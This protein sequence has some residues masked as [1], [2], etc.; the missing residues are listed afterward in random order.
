MIVKMKKVSL[1]VLDSEIEES[2]NRLKEVGVLHVE[3]RSVQN[4]QLS[5]LKEIQESFEKALIILPRKENVE[6][7]E[8][9]GGNFEEAYRMVSKALTL[10]DEKR[11]ISEE[12]DRLRREEE[13]LSQW[14]DFDPAE[15]RELAD[16][17][18]RIKLFE[19]TPD[20]FEEVS[21]RPNI[22][23]ISRTKTIVRFAVALLGDEEILKDMKETPIPQRGLSEVRDNIEEKERRLEEID[24]ELL[25][26]SEKQNFISQS[27][28][29]LNE[30]IEFE[31]VKYGMGKEEKLAYL[32]GFAPL[33]KIDILR[34]TASNHGWALLVE[35]PREDDPVPTLIEN[36]KWIRIIQPVFNLMSTV[37]G[38]R[39]Y[40]ISLWFLIFFSLFFAM[41]IGDAGYG[42]LMFGLTLF[43]R[44]KM[45]KAPAEPFLLLFVMCSA[46]IIWGCLSGTWF[47]VAALAEHPAL[48]W[49]IIPGIA[50][51]GS[52][53]AEQIMLLCFTIGSVHIG[54]AHL[55]RFIERLP[56]LASIS[57]LGWISVIAG[58]YFIVKYIALQLPLN[59]VSLWLIGIGLVLVIIFAE[60]SGSFFKGLLRGIGTMPLKFLD[61]ISAFSDIVS[62]VRLFAVGLATVEVAKS[63]NAMAETIGFSIPL[64][65][66]SA[67]ILFFGH[68]LNIVMGVMAVVVHGIRLNM[69]EFSGHLGM[70]WSGI[71]YKPFRK[72]T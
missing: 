14:G 42:I 55:L 4:Q 11:D 45:P 1:V 58:L 10:T 66:L 9:P 57:E 18:I 29:N 23:I 25:K 47:G 69:L 56:S 49:M 28:Q 26:L 70:E 7:E 19:L 65:F 44:I 54:I 51:F 5:E 60:Q 52:D 12:L 41:L 46:T 39:E 61:S 62:Y 48:S 37:P 53:N 24:R 16:K 2:L 63:F 68:A 50:S 21:E 36:P 32:T 20:Q 34:K 40:D 43:A 8:S 33:P 72:Q 22:F 59:P 13:R 3:K 30:K 17:G 71:P 64:G 35:D 31:E 15:I 38:Y 6:T 67:L 27:L